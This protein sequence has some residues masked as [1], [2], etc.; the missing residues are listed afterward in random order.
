M[1]EVPVKLPQSTPHL[2]N[3]SE[4]DGPDRPVSEV[5]TMHLVAVPEGNTRALFPFVSFDTH[6]VPLALR[7][8]DVSFSVV[9]PSDPVIRLDPETGIVTA[10]RLGHALVQTRFDGAEIE[11]CAVVMTSLKNGDPSNCEE[12]RGK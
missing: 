9:Q 8:Q 1:I 12:L 11:T 7:P 4:D 2:F 3:G 6:H 10:L 5:R